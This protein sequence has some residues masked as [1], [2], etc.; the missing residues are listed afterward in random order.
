[1]KINKFKKVGSNKYKVFFDNNSM[2]IYEDVIIKYNLLYKK[3][4]NNELLQKINEDNYKASIYDVALKYISIRMRSKK[5]IEEYLIKKKYDKKDIDDV[6][7]KLSYQGILNDKE[8]CKCYVNDKIHL[9]NNGIDKIKSDLIR[10]GI[11]EDVILNAISNI[12]EN[13][14]YE[15]LEK[16]IKREIKTNTKLPINKMK[17][18]IVNRCIS[19]GYKKEDI[20]EILDSYDLTS[21]SLIEKDYMKIYNKYKSKY[22]D[23][24]L[25]AVIKS[26]L[27]QKGYTIEQINNIV[28][29]Y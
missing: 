10:L 4:I 29:D 19:L 2:V 20:C 17:N 3:E 1:M 16:I 14:L 25:K 22:D 23:V 24:K 27:Y 5:E 12:D 11:E 9:T 6:I 15:K 18:K 28:S 8:F 7:E 26:K 13:I 21:T